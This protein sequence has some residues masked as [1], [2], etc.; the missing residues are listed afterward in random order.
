MTPISILEKKVAR[1]V[2]YWTKSLFCRLS[3]ITFTNDMGLNSD[4]HCGNKKLGYPSSPGK[5]KMVMAYHRITHRGEC[6]TVS[7]SPGVMLNKLKLNFVS[8][9]RVIY[10]SK[11]SNF[12][13][14]SCFKGSKLKKNRSTITRL[15]VIFFNCIN[16]CGRLNN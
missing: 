2:H 10:F 6:Q 7:H 8:E 14:N 13:M 16:F 15:K 12:N 1:L 4:S 11:N 3:T 9:N 5:L